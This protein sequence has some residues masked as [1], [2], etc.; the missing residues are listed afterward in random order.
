V[1]SLQQVSLLHQSLL[2][3]LLE[4]RLL[5]LARS[6]GWFASSWGFFYTPFRISTVVVSPGYL[7]SDGDLVVGIGIGPRCQWSLRWR[8]TF[9]DIKHRGNHGRLSRLRCLRRGVLVKIKHAQVQPIARV[10]LLDSFDSTRT[11]FL[12]TG[13]SSTR[14]SC[15]IQTHLSSAKGLISLLVLSSWLILRTLV[16][17]DVFHSSASV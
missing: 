1:T 16:S 14:A 10:L 6:C 13:G 9:S 8:R 3:L 12:T 7:L 15:F 5:H 11:F 2:I 4:L 17:H